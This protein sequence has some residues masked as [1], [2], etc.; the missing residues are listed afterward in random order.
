MTASRY[1]LLLIPALEGYTS[2]IALAK[3]MWISE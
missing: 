1:R 3:T 2:A